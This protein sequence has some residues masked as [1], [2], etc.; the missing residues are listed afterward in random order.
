MNRYP[1]PLG[2]PIPRKTR[3]GAVASWFVCALIVTGLTIAGFLNSW[4]TGAAVLVSGLAGI[5]VG[6][7]NTVLDMG[8]DG[9]VVDRHGPKGERRWRIGVKVDGGVRWM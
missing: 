1:E 2:E 4:L 3:D 8:N 7:S 9:Y 5:M 6:F